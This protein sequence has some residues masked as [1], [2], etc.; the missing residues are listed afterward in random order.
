M[1][2]HVAD[3]SRGLPEI[4]RVL[5]PGG[6]FVAVTTSERKRPGGTAPPLEHGPFDAGSLLNMPAALNVQVSHA[7]PGASPRDW[8]VR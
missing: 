2:Y 4:A 5:R 7:A 8:R 6:A 3:L 1:L